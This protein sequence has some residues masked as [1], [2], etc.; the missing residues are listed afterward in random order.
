[1]IP[2][3]SSRDVRITF[4]LL[5]VSPATSLSIAVNDRSVEHEFHNR[6]GGTVAV[7]RTPLSRSDYSIVTVHTPQMFCPDEVCGNGDHRRLGIAL[8]DIIVEPL[9]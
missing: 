7:L 2:Y 8:S 1:L 5:N 9:G 6:D 3:T 4:C